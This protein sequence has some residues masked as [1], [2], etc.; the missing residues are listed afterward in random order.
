MTDI[1]MDIEEFCERVEDALMDYYG[2]GCKIRNLK[3][4]K[5]N[6]VVLNGISITQ[7]DRNIS[8]TI[9]MEPYYN[10]YLSGFP[11]SEVIK[12][13]IRVY[14]DNKV[15]DDVDVDFF[16]DYESVK[17]KLCY[18]LINYDLNRELLE[19][20]PYIRYLDLAIVFH[21]MVMND[22]LGN[23][24]ILI[25]NNHM[26][27]WKVDTEQLFEDASKNMPK[28]FPPEFQ[29]M[30]DIVK[31]IYDPG[32]IGGTMYPMYVLTNKSKINGAAT[33]LY[34]DVLHTLS[35]DLHGDFYI[36][37]SSVHEVI[38]VPRHMDIEEERL[39]Q[40]VR[41][42]N[43]TQLQAEEVL[44]D[45]AYCYLMEQNQVISLPLIPE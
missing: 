7:E 28:L 10:S 5:T 21:C 25:H 6:N 41:E 39:S 4:R 29:S 18:K 38:L 30:E 42:V 26:E 11:F 19:D 2:N 43:E 24:S 31:E 16:E 35:E 1:E 27:S 13:V 40:M 17:R 15:T 37:P 32:V 12:H 36:L 44:S 3:V 8:P 9:Y 23:G 20:V 22:L 45:H 33:I 14:E 34:Q